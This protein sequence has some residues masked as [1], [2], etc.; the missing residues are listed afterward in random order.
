MLQELRTQH[1]TIIQM[2]FSGFKNNE[3]ADRLEMAP[4]TVSQIIRSPLGQAYLKGLQ[5]KS[6]EAV[7]D[8]RKKLLSLNPK[9]LST[10]ERILDPKE[11]APHSVQLNAAK[12]ILDRTGY[13]AP[14]KLQVDMTLQTKTDEEIEAE[15]NAVQ[16]SID[17]TYLQDPVKTK[18]QNKEIPKTETFENPLDTFTNEQDLQEAC[19][20]IAMLPETSDDIETPPDLLDCTGLEELPA[21]IFQKSSDA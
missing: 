19:P 7:L 1:R 21:D 9:A 13:K 6:Q 2:V 12:D 8:V 4:G 11:K 20:E 5:D 18:D 15:I 14:D 17:K 10:V 16:Q 3:I